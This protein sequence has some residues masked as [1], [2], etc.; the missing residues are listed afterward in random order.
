MPP[1]QRH[2]ERRSLGELYLWVSAVGS[3]AMGAAL[4]LLPE[5]LTT[6]PTMVL[7][8]A[9]ADRPLWGLAWTIIGA[10][11]L[12]AAYRPTE[13]RF[14]AMAALVAGTQTSWAVGLTI[15]AFHPQAILNVLVPLAWFQLASSAF[16]AARARHRPVL[17]GHAIVTERRKQTGGVEDRREHGR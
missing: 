16:V 13:A 1:R 14:V 4:T 2:H 11:C 12:V 5:R 10:A 15:P 8:Y 7:L 6:G 17:P 3:L 9:V